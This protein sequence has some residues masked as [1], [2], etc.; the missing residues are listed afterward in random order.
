MTTEGTD[1]ERGRRLDLWRT[2]ADRGGP[3]Q[4]LPEL[5][6]ELRIHRG[7]QGVYRD[8]ELTAS[9]T[10]SG[11]G[12]AVG[13]LHTGSTY[14]DDL[15][16]DGVIYHYPQ[17]DRGRRDRNE[18][19]AMKACG[20]HVLP[21]FVV[22]TPSTGAPTRIIR[23]GWVTD[24]D[25]AS[26]QILIT[27]SVAPVSPAKGGEDVD[28][29]AFVLKTPRV[30]RATTALARPAQSRFRFGVFKR[31]GAA[32]VFCGIT[33][34]ALLE[35]THLCPVE[36]GGSDD[37]RNGLV[38]CPT[39]HKAFDGGLLLI[40]PHTGIVRTDARVRDLSAIGVDV[41]SIDHLGARPHADALMWAWSR[42]AHSPASSDASA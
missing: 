29:D 16:E 33:Q 35:A 7:Q 34:P 37:P 1:A 31:Y 30:L 19:E 5:I 20:E 36:D 17:T 40:E 23:L 13:L 24:H 14:A 32:C 41:T 21:L 25:D 10:P 6:R 11:S 4:V 22:I 2:L 39:H 28:A 9:L 8:Q 42:H 3:D 12:I 27:F 38:M 18:I 15:F 26:G